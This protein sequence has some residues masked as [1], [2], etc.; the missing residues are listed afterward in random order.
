[1]SP[2]P[3]EHEPGFHHESREDLEAKGAVVRESVFEG[4]GSV[5][6]EPPPPPSARDEI[7]HSAGEDADQ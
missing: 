5:H 2:T 4:V 1:M 3:S 7:E 6:P